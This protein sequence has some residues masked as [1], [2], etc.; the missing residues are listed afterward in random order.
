MHGH[1]GQTCGRE[2]VKGQ[3]MAQV[4]HPLDSG[5][6]EGR[7]LAFTHLTKK[8]PAVMV[9]RACAQFG[10]LALNKTDRISTS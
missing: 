10:D 4:E 2:R 3:L 5:L 9:C 8:C 6:F 7:D 1:V